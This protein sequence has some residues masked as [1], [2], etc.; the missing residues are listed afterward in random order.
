M[1]ERGLGQWA[2]NCDPPN[3]PSFSERAASAEICRPP[4]SCRETPRFTSEILSFTVL[5]ALYF[6]V[7]QFIFRSIVADYGSSK[8][9]LALPTQWLH[10]PFVI[11]LS[12]PVPND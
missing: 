9:S 3:G 8:C 11:R 6:P 1:C 2:V 10:F 12:R 5:F 4:A 7:W